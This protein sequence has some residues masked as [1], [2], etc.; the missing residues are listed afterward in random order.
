MRWYKELRHRFDPTKVRSLQDHNTGPLTVITLITL[1]TLRTLVQR[2]KFVSLQPSIFTAPRRAIAKLDLITP[3]LQ[4]L[5]LF[6]RNTEK[7]VERKVA[8]SI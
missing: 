2:H 3:D 5:T 4:M 1:I 7:L 8:V 6:K